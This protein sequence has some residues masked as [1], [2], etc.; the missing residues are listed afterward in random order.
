[1]ARGANTASASSNGDLITDQSSPTMVN[2]LL[3]LEYM[4]YITDYSIIF[5]FL[6]H[7]A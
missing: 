2:N 6:V 1:M 3:H 7:R 4:H 5:F